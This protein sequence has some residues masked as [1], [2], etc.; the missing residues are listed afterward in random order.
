MLNALRLRLGEDELA[1]VVSMEDMGA[2]LKA[3]ERE[4]YELVPPLPPTEIIVGKRYL[5]CG[6]YMRRVLAIEPGTY[7][8]HTVWY[9]FFRSGKTGTSSG[10]LRWFTDKAIELLKD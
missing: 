1:E 2:V 6:G 7:G 5:C 3:L 4:G 9:E 10:P 8:P